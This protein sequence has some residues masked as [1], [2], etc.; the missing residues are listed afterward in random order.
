MNGR[1]IAL[2]SLTATILL[3][4]MSACTGGINA[5]EKG[6]RAF[7]AFAGMLIATLGIMWIILGREK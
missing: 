3:I 1:L 7:I 5:G 2:R 4:A 6:G